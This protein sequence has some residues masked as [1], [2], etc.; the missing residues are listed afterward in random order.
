[1]KIFVDI[2]NY[3]YNDKLIFKFRKNFINI[4]YQVIK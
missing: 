4:S 1:M 3:Y 2:L